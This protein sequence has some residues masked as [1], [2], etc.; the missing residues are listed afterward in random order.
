MSLKRPPWRSISRG[1][2]AFLFVSAG[3][4]HFVKTSFFVGIVPS[5][6]PYPLELVYIS[7]VCEIL[8]GV[9]VLIPAV[10][11]LAGFGLIALLVAVFPA[12]IHMF[13][14]ELRAQGLSVAA[15]LLLLRLP[16]QFVLIA[17][18]Y[19]ATREA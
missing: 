15:L 19:F 8:G 10:R 12:N 14:A 7:G 4:L 6:L 2:L 17:W 11:R 5:Y 13:V 1:L 16:L 3:V 9:G 18:V